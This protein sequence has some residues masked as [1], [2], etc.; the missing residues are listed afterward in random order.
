MKIVKIIE[1]DMGHRILHHRSV[2]RGLHGHRY[3][4]E[5]GVSGDMVSKPDVSEEGMVIDFSDIKKISNQFI[6]EKL[7][8]AF[9]VWEK[10]EELIRFFKQ[11]KG[12]KPVIVP[13]TP[14]A[15]NMAAYIFNELQDKFQDVYKTGL[16]LQSIKL[17]E[18]PTSFACYGEDL[19]N[20]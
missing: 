6:Q 15:E 12:H 9:M 2:C 7:D 17:W 5:I 20:L 19:N 4:V 14:T 13:F 18:T 11:S 16:H 1:W 10:D 3:K 8:H